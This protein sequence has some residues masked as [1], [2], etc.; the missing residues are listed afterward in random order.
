MPP[1][2]PTEPRPRS[3]HF[4]LS[5]P[6][7][8]TAR[9][10][11]VHQRPPLLAWLRRLAARHRRRPHYSRTFHQFDPTTGRWHRL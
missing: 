6:F 9:Q 5:L 7:I 11:P 3:R 1:T 2:R 8:Q 10:V 4:H